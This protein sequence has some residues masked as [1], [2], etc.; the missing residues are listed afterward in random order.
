MI[1]KISSTRAPWKIPKGPFT[2]GVSVSEFL[3]LLRGFGGKSGVSSGGMWA[4]S[5]MIQLKK[6]QRHTGEGPKGTKGDLSETSSWLV[7][8]WMFLNIQA[9][10]GSGELDVKR[11]MFWGVH[12]ILSSQ[13]RCFGCVRFSKHCKCMLYFWCIS[14]GKTVHCVGYQCVFS[15]SQ[16]RVWYERPF[17]R[18]VLQCFTYIHITCRDL[19]WWLIQLLFGMFMIANPVI[20][21]FFLEEI[22]SGNL[23]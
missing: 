11:G 21:T 9:N 22:P 23:T 19:N 3:S 6:I 18:V 8:L 16:F 20:G 14:R 17:L 5:L 15:L 7:Y 10:T 1:S 13:F 2:S 12:F 4:Q